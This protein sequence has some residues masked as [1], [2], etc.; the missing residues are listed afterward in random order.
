VH[1]A[2]SHGHHKLAPGRAGTLIRASCDLA[3]PGRRR[4]G[5]ASGCDPRV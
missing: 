2:G 3:L 4:P 5:G 1:Q